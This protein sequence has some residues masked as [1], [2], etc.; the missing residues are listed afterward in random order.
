[1]FECHGYLTSILAGVI[2]AQQPVCMQVVFPRWSPPPYEKNTT[3]IKRQG[4][5]SPALLPLPYKS[6]HPAG[7]RRRAGRVSPAGS[8]R[9]N[10][11]N[12]ADRFSK[13]FFV[14]WR[15]AIFLRSFSQTLSSLL[16]SLK[17][18]RYRRMACRS[19]TLIEVTDPDGRCGDGEPA[20]I[21]SPT[22]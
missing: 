13:N 21:N 8:L 15:S 3:K 22:T 11:E 10:F 20:L 5:N 17:S 1:M 12:L 14:R 7:Q 19:R 9:K 18:L 16:L 4:M 2:I 6:S